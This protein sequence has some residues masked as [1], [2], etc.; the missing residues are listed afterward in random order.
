MVKRVIVASAVVATGAAAFQCTKPTDLDLDLY[1]LT[2]AQKKTLTDG[3]AH[4]DAIFGETLKCHTEN[5]Q[6]NGTAVIKACTV[7]GAYELSGCAAKTCKKADNAALYKINKAAAEDIEWHSATFKKDVECV[8][9]EDFT[10]E[11]GAKVTKCSAHEGKYE[12]SGCKDPATI[13]CTAPTSTTGFELK[14]GGS[15][16]DKKKSEMYKATEIKCAAT[17]TGTPVVTKCDDDGAFKLEGC[18]AVTCDKIVLPAGYLT[19]DAKGKSVDITADQLKATDDKF[20]TTVVKCDTAN[21]YIQTVAKVAPK[22]SACSA[23]D[24]SAKFEGC[25]VKPTSCKVPEN[26]AT[27]GYKGEA[28]KTDLTKLSGTVKYDHAVFSETIG[29]AE[30]Y[31]VKAGETV[32]IAKCTN[33]TEAF[34]LNGCEKKPVKCTVPSLAGYAAKDGDDAYVLPKKDASILSNAALFTKK[35][36]KVSC[37]T[38]FHAKDGETPKISACKKAGDAITVEG[39]VETLT[40]TKP[41]NA[42][43]FKLQAEDK[44]ESNDAIFKKTDLEC[45]KGAV[46]GAAVTIKPCTEDNKPYVLEGCTK[47]NIRP[48]PSKSGAMGSEAGAVVRVAVLVLSAFTYLKM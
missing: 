39:C 27:L 36:I 8:G 25:S 34:T 6:A 17:H 1:T 47:K 29:C 16:E 33:S 20:T 23:T 44:Y 48:T 41:T 32:S 22:L 35:A 38:G 45:A 31:Q 14:A 3:A 37:A 26:I 18:E 11:A 9:G 7:D 43:L 15:F 2:A 24:K 5:A 46:K 40:C 30:G 4:D 13:T 10:L 21:N 12:L 42:A 19:V 28:D